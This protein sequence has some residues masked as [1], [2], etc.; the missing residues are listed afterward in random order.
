MIGQ[1]TDLAITL[2]VTD[3]Q[4]SQHQES[5]VELLIEALNV[6]VLDQTHLHA[7]QPILQEI[8]TIDPQT[9]LEYPVMAGCLE[10]CLHQD[11]P[12]IADLL[13]AR[14]ERRLSTLKDKSSSTRRE[15]L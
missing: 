9:A 12:Q 3:E 2:A 1:G 10:T 7:G 14:K 5:S 11:H 15:L 4:W 6:N 8:T 13:Q